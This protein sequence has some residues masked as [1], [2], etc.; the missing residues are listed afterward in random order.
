[1]SWRDRIDNTVFTIRTGDGK[2]YY[3]SLPIGYET[4]KEFNAATFEF[5]NVPGAEI[6]RKQP[7]ARQF[8]L[9]FVFTGEDNIDQAEAFDTSCNDPRPWIVRHPMYGDINGQ[10]LSVRR[11]D[12]QLNVTQFNVDFW[13]TLITKFPV[14]TLSPQQQSEDIYTEYTEL[15]PE[16][17]ASKVDLKP[18]DLN[19]IKDN[20]N[21]INDLVKKA[22]TA[23]NYAEYQQTINNAFAA[24]DNII[25]QPIDA[26]RAIHEVI[27]A[28]SRFVIALDVRLSLLVDIYNS[29]GAI[30]N[31]LPTLNNK[32]YFE[33][34]AGVTILSLANTVVQLFNDFILRDIIGTTG[35]LVLGVFIDYQQTLDN[36]YVS[37]NNPGTAFSPGVYTQRYVLDAVILALNYLQ[38]AALN[39]K[40]RRTA[41][42]LK[43][44]HLIP[45]THKYMGLDSADQNIEIFRTINNLKNT[46][47]FLVPAGT[48]IIY[49]A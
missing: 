40:T 49:Y 42:L 38:N 36:A 1:M 27:M 35:D 28:P 6:A 21:T 12:I 25:D 33:N 26:I 8:P 39:G 7:K 11:S 46:N 22:L 14:A 20:T 32:A 15:T 9:Q 29:I 23:A 5:I 30:L 2:E 17:Y 41:L 48:E 16:E 19:T 44:E 47:V 3:P 10:P 18:A 31:E 37:I 4:S 34:A 24:V 13:E 43:D 45:L